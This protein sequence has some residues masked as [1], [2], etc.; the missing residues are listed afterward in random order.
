VVPQN[1]PGAGSLK[2][3][4]YVYNVAPKDGSVVAVIGQGVPLMQVFGQKGIQF[5]AS[6]FGWIGRMSDAV[7][8]IGVW[9]KAPAQTIA[10]TRRIETTI[11]VGGAL[12]GSVLYVQ[13][14]DALAG[15]K[16]K[17]IEGY[18]SNLAYLAM[19]RGEVDGSSSLLWSVVQAEHP[20]WIAE[21]KVRFLV[22]AGLDRLPAL[23]DVPLIQ[24]VVSSDEDRTI[25][26]VISSSDII[27]RSLLAPPDLPPARLAL[28]RRAFEAA[29][30]DPEALALAGRMKLD[31]N[32][33]SGERLTQVVADYDK[34]SP[35]VLTK[36]R[37]IAGI[38]AGE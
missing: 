33:L 22:Q 9:H 12:S 5:E 24:E 38:K 36:I 35:T 10:D 29:M 15:T 31:I 4:N 21:R 13:F 20:D 17:A 23:P 27:G 32:P 2:A 14:L 19:E 37:A 25:M 11:A 26:R 3:A 34:L 30:K 6:R 16:L 28:L 8:L 7:S 1:M 18:S